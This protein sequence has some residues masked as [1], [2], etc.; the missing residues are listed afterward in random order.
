MYRIIADNKEINATN[1]S[2]WLVEYKNLILPKRKLLGDYYDG[3][4][5][6]LSKMRFKAGR[7]IQ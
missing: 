6:L 4:M 1:L 3:K 5:K 7:I 2:E